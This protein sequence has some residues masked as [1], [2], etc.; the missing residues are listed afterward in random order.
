MSDAIDRLVQLVA[1]GIRVQAETA[2]TPNK[3]LFPEDYMD[4]LMEEIDNIMGDDDKMEPEKAPEEP[5][6][7]P[8]KTFLDETEAPEEP[9]AASTEE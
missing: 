4:D 9:V 1:V 7:E 5:A 2:V 6:P 8:T 3:N